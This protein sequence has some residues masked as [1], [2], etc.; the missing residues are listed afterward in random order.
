MWLGSTSLARARKVLSRRQRLLGAVR[1]GGVREMKAQGL[2]A[3]TKRPEGA[4]N[5][6]AMTGSQLPIGVEQRIPK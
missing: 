5:Q 6:E 3:T 2:G 1:P 4:P